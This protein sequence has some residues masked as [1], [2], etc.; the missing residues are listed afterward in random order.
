VE[1]VVATLPGTDPTGRV[2]LAAHYDT[3]FGS[4]GAAD[5]KAAV[6]AV[7][8][9][10]RALVSGEA[11]RNDVVVLLT[12]GE[13]PGML[14]AALLSVDPLMSAVAA[15]LDT[16]KDRDVRHALEPLSQLADR[17]GVTILG[18]AHFRKANAG[19]PL[20]MA[21]GSA[22]F[23]N[24]V[25]AALG[26]AR[27]VDDD[28]KPLDDGSCVISMIKNNLGAATCRPCGTAW[29]PRSSSPTKG[30]PTSAAW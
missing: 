10:V 17:A 28:G 9:T 19:D 2:L 13:E 24:V 3:T 25:R 11:P 22:A 16:H 6:A 21:M 1:N 15:G 8:E 26:F 7:L 4:P 20:M 23:G 14:G 5:D 29:T 30:R 27:D 18:N 12:D